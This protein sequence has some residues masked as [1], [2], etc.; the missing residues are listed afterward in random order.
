MIPR[1]VIFRLRRLLGVPYIFLLCLLA[2]EVNKVLDVVDLALLL[3]VIRMVER[4]NDVVV[5]LVW[6]EL[7]ADLVRAVVQLLV[8]IVLA[9][10]RH[11]H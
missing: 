5:I 11:H 10:M 1:S 6:G 7:G 3:L 8:A 2:L 4:C 9:G